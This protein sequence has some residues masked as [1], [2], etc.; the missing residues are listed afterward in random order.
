MASYSLLIK[1]SAAR[2][3]EAL[4]PKDRRRIVRRIQVLAATPRPVGAEKLTGEEKYRLR[5]GDYRI[6]YTIDDAERAVVVVRI[7]QRGDVYR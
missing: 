6:L 4:P 2:E 3:L 7:G 1:R 5:Q